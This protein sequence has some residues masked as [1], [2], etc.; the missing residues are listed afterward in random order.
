MN[1]ILGCVF[2]FICYDHV[3]TAI[4]PNRATRNSVRW[5]NI[6][7]ALVTGFLGLVWLG[8]IGPGPA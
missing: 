1:I 7:L 6:A 2:L 8:L 5:N 4:E 3:R